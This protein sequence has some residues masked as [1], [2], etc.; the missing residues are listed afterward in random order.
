MVSVMKCNYVCCTSRCSCVKSD[1]L[2]EVK[3]I[4][5]KLNLGCLESEQASA[6][7]ST[8]KPLTNLAVIEQ[9]CG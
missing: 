6:A 3:T 4:A 8:F 9:I 7:C 5:S 2:T 1:K